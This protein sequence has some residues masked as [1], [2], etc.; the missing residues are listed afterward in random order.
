[1]MKPSLKNLPGRLRRQEDGVSMLIAVVVAIAIIGAISLNF[2]AETSQKQSGA[3]VAYTSLNA[4][5]VADAGVRYVEKC[6]RD[7]DANCPIASSTDWK[8]DF[9][10]TPGTKISKNFPSN[11]GEEFFTVE[12][13]QHSIN[14]AD[15]IRVTSTGTFRG[16]ERVISSTVSRSSTCVL[17]EQAISYCTGV[18]ILNSASSSDPNGPES[19][20]PVTSVTSIFPSGFPGD[21]SGC[22]DYPVYSNGSPSF[23]S[24]YQYCSFTLDGT[25]SDEIGAQSYFTAQATAGT[26][27]ISVSDASDFVVGMKVR[28]TPGAQIG[29]SGASGTSVDLDTNSPALGSSPLVKIVNSVTGSSPY[30]DAEEETVDSGGG[31][32]TLTLSDSLIDTYGT[33]A[34]ADFTDSSTGVTSEEKTISSIS[35][36]D[37]TFTT[38]LGNAYETGSNAESMIT[39]YVANDFKMSNT[40]SLDVKGILTIN[41]GGEMELKNSSEI[42]VYGALDVLVETDFLLSNSARINDVM[43]FAGDLLVQAVDDVSIKNSTT[44]K[45]AILANDTVIIKNNADVTGSISGDSVTLSN[46]ATLTY[47]DGAGSDSEGIGNCAPTTFNPPDQSGG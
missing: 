19:V 14:D 41:I 12:F 10:T 27:T 43:S 42:L 3:S 25:N 21:P 28:L 1:M 9:I 26:S 6:L 7:H 23:A 16:A 5:L 37:I 30:D 33:S 36:N 8:T 38:P 44:F 47:D 29:S 20:C 31:T 45:G 22:T 11:T 4:F 18:N 39:M 2:L 15:N 17:G 40:S 13:S 32:S 34:A 46:N 35:V 24:P